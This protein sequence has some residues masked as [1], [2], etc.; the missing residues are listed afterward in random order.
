MRI[1]RVDIDQFRGYLDSQTF[2]CSANVV[3]LVGPNGY[4][5]T[6][7][8]DAIAWCLF[9]TIR[10][11]L[12]S[13]DAQRDEYVANRFDPAAAAG[14]R[15]YFTDG[16]S[17]TT[18]SRSAST[19]IVQTPDQT[20]HQAR[21][22]A[23]ISD[24][25]TRARGN[26]PQQPSGVHELYDRCYALGQEEMAAFLRNTNPRDRFDALAS[27]LGIDEV[28]A[29]FR[30]EQAVQTGLHADLESLTSQ[31]PA[32]NASIEGLRL[33][34]ADQR[35][36]EALSQGL[37]LSGVVRDL[38]DV[39][40]RCTSDGVAKLPSIAAETPA[41]EAAELGK[42]IAATLR[43]RA[44]EALRQVERVVRLETSADR[45]A[46]LRTSIEPLR[47]KSKE[48]GHQVLSA[49]TALQASRARAKD[50][51]QRQD[52]LNE[53]LAQAEVAWRSVG[54]FL[55]AAR[56]QL[57]G[58][59]C[60]LCGQPIAQ[61]DLLAEIER[62][63]SG[64]PSSVLELVERR[65]QLLE[66]DRLTAAELQQRTAGQKAVATEQRRV[67]RELASA[68]SEVSNWDKQLRLV[69]PNTDPAAPD[70]E[71]LRTMYSDS[72]SR[73]HS[74]A[75]EVDTLISQAQY[76][77]ELDRRMALVDRL[78]D[79]ESKRSALVE[80]IETR[81]RA[82]NKLDSIIDAAQRAEV[83]IVRK[84]LARQEPIM[85]ALYRRLRP[86]PV[87]DRLRI[88]YRTRDNRGEVYFRAASGQ[89]DT[90]LTTIFSS[91]QLNAVALCAF[92]SMNLSLPSPRLETI[93]LDDPIQNMDD[94][95]VLGLLD[96][97]RGLRRDRQLIISTHDDQLGDLVQ[98]KLRPLG[99]GQR[100]IRHQ[101]VAFAGEGPTVTTT[102]LEYR[103]EPRF[104]EALAV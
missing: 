16:N 84:V 28:R 61:H 51:K 2:D 40:K 49:E 27:L 35:G 22:Q 43:S 39:V 10:R 4:G 91:A 104:V 12:G 8:F 94:F 80:R 98:R 59:T 90:N 82:A 86:H 58:D 25:L 44:E 6:S 50:A 92:L 85:D 34:D 3:L 48:L 101:F 100:L 102:S 9:G 38:Q 41:S 79:L 42:T 76:H 73:T 74:F 29:F 93:M 31:L 103:P 32:L 47:S 19:L 70:W 5:K 71:S 97:L 72:A 62:R 17:V 83:A 78:N 18:V 53:E 36:R 60:P 89:T 7:F 20:L 24:F 37:G 21:A 13:R 57:V 64:T 56:G 45:I 30:H 46:S 1:S 77:A 55:T 14:V 68:L 69:A 75:S 87:L 23:W 65:Q 99:S 63:L 33:E 54:E 67:E 11:L 88:E 26:Q 52:Q 66:E 81:R 15:L 95:N 96:L